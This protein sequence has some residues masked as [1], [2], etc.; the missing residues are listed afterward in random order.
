MSDGSNYLDPNRPARYASCSL[1]MET[2]VEIEC[3]ALTGNGE[4]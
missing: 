2:G 4:L 3:I 1:A